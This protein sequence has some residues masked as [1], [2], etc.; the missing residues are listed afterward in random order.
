MKKGQFKAFSGPALAG[1]VLSVAPL[2]FSSALT[3]LTIS[4]E[5]VV[6]Q[7][8][9]WEW[10]LLTVA[11]CLTSTF[12]LTPPTFLAL[13][14]GYFLGWNSLLPLFALNMAAI[15][16]VNRLINW[17]DQDRFV[18]FIEQNPKAKNVLERIR[19]Q[20][21]KVIFF[22]KL[23]PVL[24]FAVTNLVFALSGAR[25]RNILLG[26]FLGMIP[27]TLIA[28]WTAQQAKEI[29]TLVENPNAGNETQL[30]IGV[31]LL[32]SVLGLFAVLNRT[33]K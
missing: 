21:L 20:E 29:R 2:L 23:S 8:N 4:N 17:L 28:V 7:F 24:P 13:I 25:L 30:L 1:L 19:G 9:A 15:L 5:A 32:A 3:Y 14:F 10:L 33:L 31:L 16:L 6:A 12:A 27:R 18:R 26:G 22:T 11:C